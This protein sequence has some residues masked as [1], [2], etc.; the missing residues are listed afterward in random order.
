MYIGTTQSYNFYFERKFR[1]PPY[2]F[3]N[4]KD[5]FS[6]VYMSPFKC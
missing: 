3:I 5:F 1:L 4:Q 2:D 6:I